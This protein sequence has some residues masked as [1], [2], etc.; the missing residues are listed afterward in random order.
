[1]HIHSLL[2]VVPDGSG[3]DLIT[4]DLAGSDGIV[5]PVARY[6][7]LIE[8]LCPTFIRAEGL[9][10]IGGDTRELIMIRNAIIEMMSKP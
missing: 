5:L 4:P 1:M 9:A 3:T 7:D 10:I 2:V 8:T 6:A